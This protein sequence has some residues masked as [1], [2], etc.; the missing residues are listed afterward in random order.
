MSS[1]H[2][3][4]WSRRS[5]A[6]LIAAGVAG[7]ALEPW[8][9]EAVAAVKDAPRTALPPPPVRPRH[10]EGVVRLS[11]NENPAGPS[12][13][14]LAAIE[15]TMDLVWRYPDRQIDDLATAVAEA[16]GVAADQVI[17]GAGSSEILKIAVAACTGP[18]RGLVM[19]TPTF[20][21]V[22]FHAKWMGSE[23]FSV[24]L[25]SDYRHDLGRMLAATRTP[26]LFYI[27]N[28]NNPT[29]SITPKEEIRAFLERL[30]PQSWVLLDEAYF[31]FAE[32]PRYESVMSLVASYPQLIVA[33]TFSKVYGMA[34]LRCGYGVAQAAAIEALRK[35]T[36]FDTV[37]I[38]AAVAARASLADSGYVTLGR[39]R[40]RDLR[41][42]VVAE[43]QKMG[44]A[45]IPSSANFVM[46]DLRTP[47]GP[48]RAALREKSVEV[49]RTFPALPNHLR[50]SIGLADQMDAFL[51]AFRSVMA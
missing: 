3:Y 21:P 5:L 33:R 6:Q 30:P 9:G 18:G 32:D 25:T 1:S 27:C 17:L 34:G 24:P 4:V 46:I 28:P 29:A 31:H 7:L 41:N 19:A 39:T 48:V 38:L 45:S 14:A 40:N 36:A 51:T 13:K 12:P 42:K 50:V 22:A 16:N 43:V 8:V 44:F 26:G 35:Q 49:G 2:P 10:A 20:E 15:D 23:V 11:S 37:N 47:V